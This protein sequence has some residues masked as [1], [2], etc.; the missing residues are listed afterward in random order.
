MYMWVYQV[1]IV[2]LQATTKVFI[3][4][5]FYQINPIQNTANV[6]EITEFKNW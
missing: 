3:V 1:K 5:I 4:A 2:K 6:T